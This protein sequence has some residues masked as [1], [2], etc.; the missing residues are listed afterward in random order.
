MVSNIRIGAISL[1]CPDPISLANFYA[2]LLGAEVA[3]QTENF[4][5]I[6][7]GGT[8]LSMQKADDHKFSTWPNS[9]VPQQIHLDFAV[10]DLDESESVAIKAGATRAST[11]PSPD[12]WRV[13]IDPAGHPFCLTT[14]IPD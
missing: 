13:M 8:W 5:A 7:I 12:R 10:V 9:K 14:L 3:F 1:D 6:H 4:A 11:Q 2:A